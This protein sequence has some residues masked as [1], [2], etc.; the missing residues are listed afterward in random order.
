MPVTFAHPAAVVPL[1]R[2]LPLSALIVGSLTPDFEY[3]LR[4]AAVSRFSHTGP[5]ILYFCV[6]VGF[7]CLW[8]FH[9]LI[10]RPVVLLLPSALRERLA[11]LS[12]RFDFWPAPRL[13]LILAALAV[14]ALSHIIWD[15]FTHEYG[16]V[17][18][19]WPVLQATVFAF[20]GHELKLYKLL[21]YGSSLLG[22]LLLC[23]FV[24]RWMQQH[25]AQTGAAP[26]QFLP[27]RLRRA[28]VAT[29]LGATCGGAVLLGSWAASQETGLHAVQV[30]VV[31]A[32]I[33]GMLSFAGGVLL[34]SLLL[35]LTRLNY[36]ETG[37]RD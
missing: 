25:P 29:V 12:M 21:Q 9:R 6:P 35:G 14:G 33:G 18:E 2:L 36:G 4:L 32:T 7:C 24:L 15:A 26:G 28:I 1:R 3:P 22:L 19:S 34:S 31:Q 37:F 27:A 23:Y 17:V 16:F 10:K 13:L 30:F 11:T 20:A 8:I 5:G